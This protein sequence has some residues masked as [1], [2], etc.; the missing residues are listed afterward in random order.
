MLYRVPEVD[1][2]PMTVRVVLFGYLND[3]LCNKSPPIISVENCWIA[4]EPKR[5]IKFMCNI[6]IAFYFDVDFM[7]AILV[8]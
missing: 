5:L 3:N 2:H 8:E 7:Y 4:N 1:D 6:V